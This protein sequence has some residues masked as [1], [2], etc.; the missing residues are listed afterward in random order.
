M[1]PSTD[2][3]LVLF[4]RLAAACRGL[5]LVLAYGLLGNEITLGLGYSRG[6]AAGQGGKKALGKAVVALVVFEN[7]WDLYLGRP[8]SF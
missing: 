8:A 7:S 3:S 4:P 5:Q 6:V 1:S 2:T